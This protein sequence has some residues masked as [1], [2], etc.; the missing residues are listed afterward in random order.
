MRKVEPAGD[1]R[2]LIDRKMSDTDMK[3]LFIPPPAHQACQCCTQIMI[4][5][6]T[7]QA[8][9]VNQKFQ[10]SQVFGWK[11]VLLLTIAGAALVSIVAISQQLFLRHFTE[12]HIGG[13]SPVEFELNFNDDSWISD[14]GMQDG[15]TYSEEALNNMDKNYSLDIVNLSEEEGEGIVLNS[16]AYYQP[17]REY[18]PPKDFDKHPVKF[19]SPL[20]LEIETGTKIVEDGMYWSKEVEASI[21]PGLGDNIIEAE[22]TSLRSRKVSSL[23]KPT[24]LK[25]GR[26][27]NRFVTFKDGVHAC[28]RYREPHNQLVLGELMSF[29]LARLLGIHNVPAVI[30]SQVDSNNPVW[31]SAMKDIESAHW[32]VGAV[33]AIIQWVEGLKRDKMPD[34]VRRALLGRTTIDVTSDSPQK[35]GDGEEGGIGSLRELDVTEA[36]LMAQ[37]SDLVVFDFITGNY[38]RVASMQDAAEKEKR[39]DILSETVH[40]LASSSRTGSIWLIDNESGMLDSYNL[41][42]PQFEDKEAELE[43]NRFQRMQLDLLQTTC[44]FRRNTVD[45]VFSLYRSGENLP[46]L[47][48]SFIANNEPLYPELLASLRGRDLAYR[49]HLHDRVTEVWTWMKQCQENVKFW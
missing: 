27:Q 2:L 49:K 11:L 32:R 30:L 36:A 29:Y 47:L 48:D 45:R 40:N 24:W 17:V 15:P 3:P 9:C 26:D 23:E 7:Q 25:C 1:M 38:D 5:S 12:G 39:P 21:D 16:G 35:P 33:V 42:Y 41:L 37:W 46:S 13:N 44:I 34:M 20:T 14:S 8:A 4:G 28:A 43:A 18:S 31:G 6:T 19:H 22:L 10:P